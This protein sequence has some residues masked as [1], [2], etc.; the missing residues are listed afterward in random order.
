MHS[1]THFKSPFKSSKSSTVSARIIFFLNTT[2]PKEHYQIYFTIFEA[3][4][5]EIYKLQNTL[6]YGIFELALNTAVADRWDPLVR[7]PHASLTQNRAATLRGGGAAKA[8]R[9]R[10]RRHWAL[11][12]QPP[13]SAAALFRLN[14]MWVQL[15]CRPHRSATAV[16][17]ASSKIPD[18]SVICHF[19]IFRLVA[20]KFVK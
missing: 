14:D 5:L 15:T 10:T 13:R 6:K 9:R 4:K 8:R 3:T 1:K 19:C 17:R 2:L 12:A 18:S 11:A 7:G 16:L 20:P